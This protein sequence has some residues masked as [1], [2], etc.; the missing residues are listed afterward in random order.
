MQ[1]V[2]REV[3]NDVRV[4]MLVAF[5]ALLGLVVA[6][7]WPWK[8]AIETQSKHWIDVMTAVGT[9]G[10]AVVALGI[11]LRDGREGRRRAFAIAN[12]TAAGMTF[13][14]ASAVRTLKSAMDWAEA[15]KQ[16]D[17]APS[18]FAKWHL[19]LSRLEVC[20]RDEQL[21]V[22]PLPNDCAYKLAGARDRLHVAKGLFEEFSSS[23]DRQNSEERKARAG[24][25]SMVLNEAYLLLDK[26]TG[27]CQLASHGLTS[28]YG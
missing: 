12:L 3:L 10:A 28:P 1:Q 26:A 5:G 2:D 16:F 21:A 6:Y 17:C 18:D 15:T 22:V 25:L 13:R 14:L 9:V 24:L 19:T 11:A 27:E 20:S 4:V 23:A 8:T 7:I